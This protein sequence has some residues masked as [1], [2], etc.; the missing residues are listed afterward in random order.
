MNENN[1]AAS[2]KRKCS[3]A[4]ILLVAGT[5]N[6]FVNKKNGKNYFSSVLYDFEKLLYPLQ[7]LSLENSY[8]I[9]IQ[10]K[11]GGIVSQLNSIELAISKAL[12]KLS[13]HNRFVLSKHG[14]LYSD[15]RIKER[16]KYG[17]RKARKAAQYHKR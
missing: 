1:L 11:G 9:F 15:S 6:I 17:L 2:A 3:N 8:D 5:G 7:L 12:A 4:K 16:K 13:D 10:V 14:L